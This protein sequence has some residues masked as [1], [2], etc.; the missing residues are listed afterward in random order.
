M[1]RVAD[2][3]LDHRFETVIKGADANIV[4]CCFSD[5]LVWLLRDVNSSVLYKI[6]CEGL[7]NR[8][9]LLMAYPA[10]MIS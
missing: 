8:P 2:C 10:C 9:L 1:L 5:R 7:V 4:C 6:V 3:D